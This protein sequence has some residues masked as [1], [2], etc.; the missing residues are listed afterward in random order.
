MI[1]F[2][3]S[4]GCRG[5]TDSSAVSFLFKKFFSI[6]VVYFFFLS[7]HHIDGLFRLCKWPIFFKKKCILSYLP[8]FLPDF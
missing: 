4:L 5:F 7:S 8:L 2:I 3:C 1:N 6:Y